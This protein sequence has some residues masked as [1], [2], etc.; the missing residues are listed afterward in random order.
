MIHTHSSILSQ[1][2]QWVSNLLAQEGRYGVVSQMSRSHDV[3]RQTLYTWKRKGQA[4]LEG[5]LARK[6][7][8]ME[9]DQQLERAILTLLVEGHASYRGI[10]RC[11]WM[12][13]GM[14]VSVG[15]IAAVVQ[16]TGERAQD[17]MSHHAPETLRALA[18]DEL[19]GSQ[20]G[21]A[22]QSAGRRPQWGGMGEYQSCRS[23]WG[24]L[25]EA[26]VADAGARHP[27]ADHGETMGGAPLRRPS[28]P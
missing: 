21:Q 25:D 1:R 26:H 14:Q 23:G 19:Y 10:Q 13:L 12:L 17:W 8:P 3:S 5:A 18:L 22:Y 15:K 4:A 6:Q 20:H 9:S 27:L 2:V 11:L 7:E 28:A 24:E 16:Q